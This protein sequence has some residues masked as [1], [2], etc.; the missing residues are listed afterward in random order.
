MVQ[1]VLEGRGSTA[2]VMERRSKR[3]ALDRVEVSDTVENVDMSL[4]ELQQLLLRSHQQSTV[5]AGTNA[6][7]D[8]FSLS[9]PL[10]E[11]NFTEMESNLKSAT[12]AAVTLIIPLCMSLIQ[13]PCQAPSY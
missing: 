7:M 10:T 8:P 12:D 2:S 3:P 5:E 4:E 6:V 13:R 1:S 9:L 11:W